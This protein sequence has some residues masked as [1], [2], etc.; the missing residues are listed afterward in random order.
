MT[1]PH[2]PISKFHPNFTAMFLCKELNSMQKK[3]LKKYSFKKP[4][5]LELRY[6]A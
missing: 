6:F 1:S 3:K 2:K 5:E 4:K